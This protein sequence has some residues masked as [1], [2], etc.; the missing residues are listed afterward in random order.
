[1][2]TQFEIQQ[3]KEQTAAAKRKMR[4][5]AAGIA[6][7]LAVKEAMKSGG[8]AG[9]RVGSVLA[10]VVDVVSGVS[11][12]AWSFITQK[13]KEKK[14]EKRTKNQAA[15]QSHVDS[16]LDEINAAGEALISSGLNPLTPE[17]E[18]QLYNNLF[19]KVGYRG[20]CNATVWV[21]GSEPGPNRAI[22]FRATRD[23]KLLTPVSMPEPPQDLQTYWYSRCHGLKDKW[24]MAYQDQLVQ[25]GRSAELEELQSTMKKGR[26]IVSGALGL[27]MVFATLFWLLNMRR[28][29]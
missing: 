1:L 19:N 24:I 12:A 26:W 2:A 27:V 13:K 7:Q 11:I 16:V 5:A 9:F 6:A 4:G 8:A 23:G 29:K 17:F 22:M 18:Q 14:K 25:Q 28:I 3:K 20:H 15:V 10:T 21:P